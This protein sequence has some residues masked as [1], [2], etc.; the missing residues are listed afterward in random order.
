MRVRVIVVPWLF[1]FAGMTAW[2]LILV[3]RGFERNTTLM[4]HELVHVDQFRAWPVTF[5][6]R[7]VIAWVRAGFSYT[8]N[9]FEREAR[10]LQSDPDYR[11]RANELIVRRFG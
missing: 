1:G 6:V 8:D 10:A 7:Y 4:A 9:E 3:K 11:R 5:P 2:S